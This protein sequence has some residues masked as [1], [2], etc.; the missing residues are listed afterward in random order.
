V[1]ST[2]EHRV[3][4]PDRRKT[5]RGGRRDSDK[6]GFA[7]LVMVADEHASSRD[8]CEA[9]LA[10]LRFAVAPVE[11]IERGVEVMSSLRPDVI[12]AKGRDVSPLQRAA[13]TGLPFVVV[14]EEM[15][16]PEKLVEAI[17]RA[18]RDAGGATARE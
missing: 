3:P 13:P 9:I 10:K 6:Q 14:T 2:P 12:V 18:I 1:T 4:G 17:R 16:D 5:T 11:S 7:P 8:L 15:R